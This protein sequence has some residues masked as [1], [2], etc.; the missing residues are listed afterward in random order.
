MTDPF[1]T[2]DEPVERADRKAQFARFHDEYHPQLVA[3]L[4]ALRGDRAHANRAAQRAFVRA[5]R[6][7]PTVGSLPDPAGWTRQ[8]ARQ[9]HP[10]RQAPRAEEE[11]HQ[12]EWIAKSARPMFEALLEL[13]EQQ[14]TVVALHHVGGLA[15]ELV[16]DEEHLSLDAVLTLLASGYQALAERMGWI[17]PGQREHRTLDP[18]EPINTWIAI[19]LTELAHALSDQTD[20]R[21][22]E[23]VFGRAIRHRIA[24]TASTAAVVVTIGSVSA[25][26]VTQHPLGAHDV[27]LPPAGAPGPTRPPWPYSGSVSTEAPP[28]SGPTRLPG[29]SPV[30]PP[31]DGDE[32][33]VPAGSTTALEKYANDEAAET[34]GPAQSAAN[35]RSS[36]S[37]DLDKSRRSG[38]TGRFS[39]SGE[40]P[41]RSSRGGHTLGHHGDGHTDGGPEGGYG[42]GGGRFGGGHTDGGGHSSGGH[43]S[44]GHSGGGHSGGGHSSGGHSGGGHSGGGH[45]GGGHGH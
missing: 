6:R 18:S 32:S 43:S 41:T 28:T 14:R 11:A 31:A 1:H 33:L 7:W 13:P 19:E 3:L 22:L 10:P 36:C 30:D 4:H 2:V 17:P 37:A 35:T 12:P 29:F 25:F 27:A 23:H 40:H 45:S 5:W 16:A 39:D 20:Q 24:V 9:V 26:A 44:E 34:S 38:S 8:Q 42:K 15:A 21:A